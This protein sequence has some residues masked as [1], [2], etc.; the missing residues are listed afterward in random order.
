MPR[1]VAFTSKQ[2][3]SSPSARAKTSGT[4]FCLP[5]NSCNWRRWVSILKNLAADR[6]LINYALYTCGFSFWSR[7]IS[8]L[9]CIHFTFNPFNSGFNWQFFWRRLGMRCTPPPPKSATTAMHTIS[10]IT[11]FNRHIY[12]IY[13]PTVWVFT[14]LDWNLIAYI[15]HISI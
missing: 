3:K 10:L 8:L 5:N 11:L 2:R 13:I 1:F 14:F 4:I 15:A 6:K 9:P 7:G 12:Y